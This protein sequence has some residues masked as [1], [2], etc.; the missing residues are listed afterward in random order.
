MQPYT[1]IEVNAS[2]DVDQLRV[3]PKVIQLISGRSRLEHLVQVM[4]N[5]TLFSGMN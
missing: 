1:S 5:Y 3:L 2:V 4:S